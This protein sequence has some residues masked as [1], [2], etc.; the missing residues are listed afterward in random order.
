MQSK[1]VADVFLN[2][3]DLRIDTLRSLELSVNLYPKTRRDVSQDLNLHQHRC[4][5]LISQR[6]VISHKTL[7]LWV[8][9]VP[10][11]LSPGFYGYNRGCLWGIESLCDYIVAEFLWLH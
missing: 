6:T 10:F 9:H 7:C 4:E 3:L 2:S 5:N 11:T 1:M 8:S